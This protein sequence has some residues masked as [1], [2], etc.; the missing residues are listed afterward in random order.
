MPIYKFKSFEDAERALWNFNPDTGYY[1][2]VSKLFELGFRLSPPQCR[3]GIFKFRS[4]E[5]AENF[6]FKLMEPDKA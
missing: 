3:R 2:Q 1:L 5:E 4:L 6:N